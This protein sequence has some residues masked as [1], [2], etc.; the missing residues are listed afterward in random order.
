MDRPP[1]HFTKFLQQFCYILAYDDEVITAGDFNISP[2]QNVSLGSAQSK[3]RIVDFNNKTEAIRQ[4]M[5]TSILT[6]PCLQPNVDTDQN[7]IIEWR[8]FAFNL[9]Q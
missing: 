7:I 3:R 8:Q 6:S 1:L 5:Q 2:F 4:K 9:I